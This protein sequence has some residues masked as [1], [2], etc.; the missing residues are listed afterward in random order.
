MNRLKLASSLFVVMIAAGHLNVE[1]RR[2]ALTVQTRIGSICVTPYLQ[3]PLTVPIPVGS[4]CTC[5]TP[6]GPAPGIAN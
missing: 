3:C 5:M 2:M 6:Q 4:P 1:P